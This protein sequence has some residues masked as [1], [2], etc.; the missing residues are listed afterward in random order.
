MK[1]KADEL[2][3]DVKLILEHVTG[4]TEKAEKT[5]TRFDAIDRKLEIIEIKLVG[6]ADQSNLDKVEQR[7]THLEHARS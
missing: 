5:E 7:V 3:R 2:H 6:K 1:K 4:L